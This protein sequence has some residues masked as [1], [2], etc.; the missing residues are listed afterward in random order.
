[1]VEQYHI[2]LLYIVAWGQLS[3]VTAETLSKFDI[4]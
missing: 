2:L 1:M 3:S 4:Q